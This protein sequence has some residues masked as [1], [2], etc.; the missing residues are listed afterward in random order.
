MFYDILQEN[1]CV[2]RARIVKKGLY[3]EISCR[4]C[5]ATPH[6]IALCCGEKRINLGICVPINDEFGFCTKIPIKAVGEGPFEFRLIPRTDFFSVKED[7]PFPY[8]S[9]LMDAYLVKHGNEV[10]VDFKE[11][12][13]DR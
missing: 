6:T 2:G 1:S 8:I 13:K 3:Y 12:S 4:D 10:G 7:K 9:R 11:K 5:V